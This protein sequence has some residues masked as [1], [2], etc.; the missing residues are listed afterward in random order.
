V[1]RFTGQIPFLVPTSRTPS[2]TFTPSTMTPEGEEGHCICSPS[3]VLVPQLW[4][5]ENDYILST[6]CPRTKVTMDDGSKET[7][8][9]TP[10]VLISFE[11]DLSNLAS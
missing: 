4:D 9:C 1:G 10:H 8:F 7:Y 2:L 3:P 11:V 6:S 5:W